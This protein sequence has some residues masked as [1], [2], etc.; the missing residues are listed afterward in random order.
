MITG[1][2]LSS[3]GIYLFMQRKCYY[4]VY[5]R[6]MREIILIKRKCQSGDIED[7]RSV[8]IWRYAYLYGLFMY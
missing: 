8:S 2:V 1:K 6:S 5:N 4:H 3:G 7:R